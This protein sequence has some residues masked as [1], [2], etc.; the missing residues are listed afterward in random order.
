MSGNTA[1]TM[2]DGGCHCG[3]IKYKAGT[4]SIDYILGLYYIMDSTSFLLT[5]K[6]FASC[7]LILVKITEI[8]PDAMVIC[9]CTDCQV[10]SGCPYRI[11]VFSSNVTICNEGKPKEYI[12]TSEA[13]SKRAQSFCPTCGTQ[14]WATTVENTLGLK[15]FS[16]RAGTILQRKDLKPSRQIWCRSKL[17]FVDNLEATGIPCLETQYGL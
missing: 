4:H 3:Y 16:I 5:P 7:R 15:G 9:H 17:D 11:V 10:L 1:T 13:G 6:C 14:L 12:K 2:V 8:N